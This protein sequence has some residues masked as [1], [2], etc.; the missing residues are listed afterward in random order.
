[1]PQDEHGVYDCQVLDPDGRVLV[2]MD[3]YRT[4]P[5]PVAVPEDVRAPL[6]DAMSAPGATR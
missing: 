1:M 6:R 4:V 3:G 2:R 5:M